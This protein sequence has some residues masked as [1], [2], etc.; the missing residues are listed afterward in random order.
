[1]LSAE[2]SRTPGREQFANKF[3][4][5]R[6]LIKL[7]EVT[8]VQTLSKKSTS[9]L[10]NQIAARSRMSDQ[11]HVDTRL[12]R[13]PTTDTR[14]WNW[15]AISSKASLHV[16]TLAP[17]WFSSPK[18]QNPLN[19]LSCYKTLNGT[20]SEHLHQH[21]CEV[22]NI[23]VLKSHVISRTYTHVPVHLR[24]VTDFLFG[25]TSLSTFASLSH[26]F[27]GNGISGREPFLS[28]AWSSAVKYF[29]L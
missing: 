18:S 26:S 27:F 10:A 3:V 22:C 21:L 5:H 13:W 8:E 4:K 1:M 24:R 15:N 25:F 6:S 23:I 28:A 11:W 14:S 7:I 19:M 9:K 29:Q 2:T 17:P 20:S 16:A 12:K